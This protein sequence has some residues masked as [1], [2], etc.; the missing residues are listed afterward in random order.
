MRP[1]ALHADVAVGVGEDEVERRHVPGPQ[2]LAEF[3][4]GAGPVHRQ[5]RRQPAAVLGTQPLAGRPGRSGRRGGGRISSTI[6]PLR[7]KRT[8]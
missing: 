8:V 2:G 4:D 1:D 5:Q 7:E 3:G 6:G